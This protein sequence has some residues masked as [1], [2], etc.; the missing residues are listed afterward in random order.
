MEHEGR[1]IAPLQ[2]EGDRPEAA[3]MEERLVLDARDAVVLQV[4][5]VHEGALL[6]EVLALVALKSAVACRRC[7]PSRVSLADAIAERRLLVLHG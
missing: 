3:H 5:H 1:A 6:G 7:R 2:V 4:L